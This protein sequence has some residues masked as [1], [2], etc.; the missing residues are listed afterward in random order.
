MKQAHKKYLSSLL[1]KK[2]LG[3]LKPSSLNQ[4]EDH[5]FLRKSLL[6]DINRSFIP[7]LHNQIHND[8]SEESKEDAHLTQ[9]LQVF[10][11]ELTGFHGTFVKKE[12]EKRKKNKAE[13]L[14]IQLELEAAKKKR[15]ERRIA[16]RKMREK[17]EIFEN[18][19]KFVIAYPGYH[20]DVLEAEITDITGDKKKKP[21]GI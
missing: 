14:R 17:T 18:L 11:S 2:F 21:I 15:K 1:S 10:Q 7:W 4:L 12:M 20:N 5:G 9:F 3:F 19:K 8:L 16:K 13:R 6:F